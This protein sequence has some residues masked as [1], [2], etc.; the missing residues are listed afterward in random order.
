MTST[1]CLGLLFLSIIFS[2][3]VLAVDYGQFMTNKVK[4]VL[5]NK[6]VRGYTFATYPLDNFGLATAYDGKVN[7]SKQICATWDCIGISDDRAVAALSDDD[8]LKLRV[9]SV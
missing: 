7:P 6:A 9:N 1:R 2:L 4:A 3:P 8:K 5:G